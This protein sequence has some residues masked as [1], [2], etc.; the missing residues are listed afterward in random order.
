MSFVLRWLGFRKPLDEASAEN[1][2]LSPRNVASAP[3]SITA[4]LPSFQRPRDPPMELDIN[5]YRA[6]FFGFLMKKLGIGSKSVRVFDARALQAEA[7]SKGTTLSQFF[8]EHGFVLIKHKTK[9]AELEPEDWGKVN[10]PGDF[11]TKNL[12]KTEASEHLKVY[13]AEVESL[14]REIIFPA[15]DTLRYPKVSKVQTGP[16]L[17]MRGPGTKAPMYG[18]G[19]HQDYCIGLEAYKDTI[20]AYIS[21]EAAEEMGA[22]FENPAI[23][24]AMTLCFWR[25]APPFKGKVVKSMPLAICDP[26][27]VEAKDIGEIR[28]KGLPNLREGCSQR[29]QQ[30]AYNEKQKW[31]YYPEIAMDEVLVIKQWEVWKEPEKHIDVCPCY[32]AMTVEQKTALEEKKFF[33][34]CF[35]TAFEDPS[36]KDKIVEPRISSEYRI[37]VFF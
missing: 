33:N 21:E 2:S 35:H 27:T 13:A 31:Y 25:P 9:L 19:I 16:L 24:G 28:L 1:P 3:P 18:E 15:S 4:T 29:L 17:Q 7:E 37:T 11:D 6:K 34:T 23:H 30:L 20:K 12:L 32:N 10:P 36:Y 26:N 8:A 5:S 22:G 14:V